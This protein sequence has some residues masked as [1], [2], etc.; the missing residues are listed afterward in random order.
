MF[1]RSRRSRH[2]I[3]VWPGF[4]DALA[5][6]LLVFI[7]VVLIFVLAQFFLKETLVGRERA[8]DQLSRQ[9]NELADTLSLER[10]KSTA[11]GTTIED[12]ST[13]LTATLAERDVLNRRLA[14]TAQ[15][16]Q[17]AETEAAQLQV[18]LEDAEATI[19]VDKERIELQLRELA[20]LQQDIAA[21]RQ[22]R[23]DLEGQVGELTAGIKQR[24]ADVLAARD[25]SKALETRLAEAQERTRLAQ[26]EIGKRDIRLREFTKQSRSRLQVLNQQIA[27]LREQLSQLSAALALAETGAK[28]QKVE[29]AELG[30]RLNVALARRVQK[31]NR[32]RSEFF[33]RLREVLGDHPD[34]RIVG[35]RFVFQSELLFP[36]ASATLV[37]AG[38]KQLAQ[39]AQTLRSVTRTI[40]ADIDWVLRVDGHTDRRPIHTTR[41]PSNW[42]LSTARALSVV[43]YLIAQ[44]IAPKRLVAAGFGEFRPLDDRHTDQ[45]Y[46]RNRRIEIKLTG[47]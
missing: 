40:P 19:G 9:I 18:R 29:I 8:L 1:A 14:L 24:D 2:G 32:Y 27:A 13:R 11:L 3:N 42:E 17:A 23:D 34:I 10:E 28:A 35:D 38:R 21:L 46:A 26:V 12:L 41:F 6:I 4:V 39:L 31:L 20:G 37:P 44:G 7:F 5:S 15:R 47:P 30:K 25:R 16:A 22:V 36:T 43:N 45:A 33:G